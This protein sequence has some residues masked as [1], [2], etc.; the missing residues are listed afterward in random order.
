MLDLVA[1]AIKEQLL[2]GMEGHILAQTDLM[3]KYTRK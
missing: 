2:Q 3:G 1:G